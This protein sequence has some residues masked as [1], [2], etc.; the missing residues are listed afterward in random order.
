MC[1]FSS[2][3][4]P[5]F[6]T[7]KHTHLHIIHT[8]TSQ[9]YNIFFISYRVHCPIFYYSKENIKFY[10]GTLLNVVTLLPQQQHQQRKVNASVPSIIYTCLPNYL[11]IT[12]QQTQRCENRKCKFSEKKC[13]H[14][15]NDI[16]WHLFVCHTK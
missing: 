12:I 5:W 10:A 13:Y 9:Y 4:C 7:H 3:R 14:Q 15:P 16:L 1:N 8:Y 6:D 11:I 2:N